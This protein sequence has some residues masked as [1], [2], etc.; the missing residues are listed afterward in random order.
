ME[1]IWTKFLAKLP[2]RIYT[3]KEE[4]LFVGKNAN[5]LGLSEKALKCHNFP[6]HPHWGLLPKYCLPV[7]WE[8]QEGSGLGTHS[9]AH[10]CLH[11]TWFYGC[12]T[13]SVVFLKSLWR[14]KQDG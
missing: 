4:E 1:S 8:P 10:P 7:G 12:F 6:E 2:L 13:T 14:N 11:Q 9:C 5:C 3:A